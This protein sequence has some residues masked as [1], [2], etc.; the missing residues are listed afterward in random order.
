LGALTIFLYLVEFHPCLRE[1]DN[2]MGAVGIF[3][4][5]AP[6]ILPTGN[7]VVVSL[8][9]KEAGRRKIFSEEK[10]GIGA[11]AMDPEVLNPILDK[12][13][14]YRIHRAVMAE[15]ETEYAFTTPHIHLNV[16]AKV[17]GAVDIIR[18]ILFDWLPPINVSTM[19]DQL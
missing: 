17:D 14:V 15:V 1:Q 9:E 11:L 12:G 13:K 16:K 5:I 6:N 2:G 4:W 18:T 7:G 3:A 19:S 8:V 10:Q